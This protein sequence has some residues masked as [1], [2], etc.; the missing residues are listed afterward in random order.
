[1]ASLRR[2]FGRTSLEER[3]VRILRGILS[4]IEWALGRPGPDDEGGPRRQGS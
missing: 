1:M 3:E 2:L 4:Q